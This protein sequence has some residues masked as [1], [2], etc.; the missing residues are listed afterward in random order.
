MPQ[1]TMDDAGAAHTIARHMKTL[2]EEF[3]SIDEY[4]SDRE[5]DAI[6]HPKNSDLFAAATDMRPASSREEDKKLEILQARR[7]CAQMV[8]E[9][10]LT[11][12]KHC[13][14]PFQALIDEELK[15]ACAEPIFVSLK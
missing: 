3:H 5:L 12:K 1:P 4:L 9:A 13:N 15:T 2:I 8:V 7:R 11:A 6:I 14:M 10:L